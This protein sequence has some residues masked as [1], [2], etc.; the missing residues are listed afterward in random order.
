MMIRISTAILILGVP[1]FVWA[2]IGL[3]EDFKS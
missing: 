1:S 3:I 2:V